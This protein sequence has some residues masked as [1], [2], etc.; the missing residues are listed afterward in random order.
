MKEVLLATA[1]LALAACAGPEDAKRQGATGATVPQ[2]GVTVGG[3][4]GPAAATGESLPGR[5]GGAPGAT[6]G[7]AA[8]TDTGGVRTSGSPAPHGTGGGTDAENLG[9]PGGGS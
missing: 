7:G 5:A 8:V 9:G 6:A 1:V 2:S 4:A 3:G